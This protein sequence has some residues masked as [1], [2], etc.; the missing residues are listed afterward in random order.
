MGNEINDFNND[1]WP[2]IFTADM[3]PPDN[4]RIKLLYGP[5]NYLEYAL[6]VMEGF[7]HSSMRNMLQMN[8]RNGPSVRS[9]ACGCFKY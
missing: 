1:T 7:Y 8:N 2:D 3:L 6:M 4:R 9:A 5:E